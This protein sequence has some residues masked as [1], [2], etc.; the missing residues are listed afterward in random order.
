M[1]IIEPCCAERQLGQLLR[2]SRGH[3]VLF[4]TNGDM[5]LQKWMKATM[6][7][8]GDRP[9]T[10][11]L[12]VPIFTAKMMTAVAKYLQLGWVERLRLLTTDPLPPEMAQ[13]LAKKAGCEAAV[14]AERV[15]LAADGAVTEELLM[16]T[17]PDGTVAVQGAMP[18]VITPGLHLYAGIYGRTGGQAVRSITDAWEARFRARRYTLSLADSADVEQA[19]KKKKTTR[20]TKK[21]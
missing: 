10:L 4:Q 14:L 11:T 1:N 18:D 9:R 17:G 2:E 16:F 15:E 8:A 13:M 5:T 7:M 6:L 12:A 20:K 3:A 21:Q 19:V